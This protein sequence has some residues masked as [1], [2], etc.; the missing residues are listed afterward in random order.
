MKVVLTNAI[1]YTKLCCKQNTYNNTFNNNDDESTF[2]GFGWTSCASATSSNGKL[3]RRN[4]LGLSPVARTFLAGFGNAGDIS[5]DRFA[6]RFSFN[7]RWVFRTIRLNAIALFTLLS[8]GR[9]I[10]CGKFSSCGRT[11][12]QISSV[13]FNIS[14]LETF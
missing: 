7:D 8:H 10:K 14:R 6:R 2:V 3:R 9:Q 13:F 11:M 5:S 12:P 4:E 1:Q